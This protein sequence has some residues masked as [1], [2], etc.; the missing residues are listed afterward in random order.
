MATR[1]Y[2]FSFLSKPR[3]CR[4]LLVTAYSVGGVDGDGGEKV[5]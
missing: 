5:S 1:S 3:G 4:T 2:D